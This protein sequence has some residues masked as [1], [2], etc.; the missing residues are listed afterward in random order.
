MKVII[1]IFCFRCDAELTNISK[2][3]PILCRGNLHTCLQK[4]YEAVN[5]YITLPLRT[6]QMVSGFSKNSEYALKSKDRIT[7]KEIVSS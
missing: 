4:K 3:Y 6:L 5:E 7:N 1:M 2:N